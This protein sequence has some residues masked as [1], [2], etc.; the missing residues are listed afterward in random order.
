MDEE[1][2]EGMTSEEVAYLRRGVEALEQIARALAPP[3]A[4]PTVSIERHKCQYGGCGMEFYD[5]EDLR[6]HRK[7][8]HPK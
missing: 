8:V 3:P 4:P 2:G 5:M 6:E 7:V 1:V